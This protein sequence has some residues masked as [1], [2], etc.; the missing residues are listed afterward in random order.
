[1]NQTYLRVHFRPKLEDPVFVAGLP[2]IGDVGRIVARLL[3]EFS[4]ARLFAE[5][6]SPTF[7]DLV[8]IDENGVCR[9]PRYEFHASTSGRNLVVLTGDAQP[10][11]EDIPAHYEVC[12]DVLDF[13][14][15]LGCRFVI[16]V[17]G[18]P[19]PDR[20][21]GI[22]VAATS[23]KIAAEFAGKNAKVYEGGR[24]GGD[25]GLLLGLARQRGLEGVCLLGST[26]GLAPDR[27]AAFKVYKFL[28][29]TLG[30]DV[31]EGL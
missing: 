2:G 22:Y 5:L 6:Y 26:L 21:E 23:E 7:P 25:S 15:E 1:M 16:T 4:H 3:I 18:A 31:Q 9:P 27:E 29:K 24:I 30:A 17:E 11:L 14:S 10:P 13:A 20:A 19:L 12:G 28:R 8:V